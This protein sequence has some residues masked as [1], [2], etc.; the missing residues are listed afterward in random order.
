MALD[1]VWHEVEHNC[2]RHSVNTRD[3][4]FYM[5]SDVYRFAEQYIADARVAELGSGTGYGANRMAKI[6]QSVRA[7]EFDGDAVS[8]AQQN[9]AAPNLNFSQGDITQ[10]LSLDPVD[11]VYS[12][13][14][15]EHLFEPWKAIQ[16]VQKILRPG[17]VFLL[18]VPC[19]ASHARMAW[20]HRNPFH[21]GNFHYGDWYNAL[22][23]AFADVEIYIQQCQYQNEAFNSL[24]QD[25]RD[26]IAKHGK[27]SLFQ[28][29][30]VLPF[31]DL[32]QTGDNYANV[33]FVCRR[34]TDEVKFDLTSSA[35]SAIRRSVFDT[36][37]LA[38]W[39][40]SMTGEDSRTLALDI[41]GW[42]GGIDFIIGDCGRRNNG[43]LAAELRTIKDGRTTSFKRR[44]IHGRELWDN[45]PTN[46]WWTFY[47]EPL[48]CEGRVDFTIRSID[49]RAPNEFNIGL[50][51][52]G[53]PA[54]RIWETISPHF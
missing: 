7:I 15:F 1:Q 12:S 20:E 19:I 13:N 22:K 49:F 50:A 47:R 42:M 24:P 34:P 46:Y 27:F 30:G 52:S 40:P 16:N 29:I 2:E 39:S 21:V 51:H 48:L 36:Y 10:P 43:Y 26:D 53:D 17:G 54:V 31:G 35:E 25:Q 5:L 28:P 6:A 41:S 11:F 14:C 44:L 3:A 18:A 32:S 23:S 45:E 9:H 38:G 33:V 4:F 8:F 37:S